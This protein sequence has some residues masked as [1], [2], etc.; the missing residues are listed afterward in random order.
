LS[1]KRVT[2]QI[3]AQKFTFYV[4]SLN[5]RVNRLIMKLDG[6]NIICICKWGLYDG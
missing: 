5:I 1:Y 4:V 6:K 2:Y 3:Y